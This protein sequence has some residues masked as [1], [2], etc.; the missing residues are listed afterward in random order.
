[1]SR[2]LFP[3][4]PYVLKKTVTYTSIYRKL[5]GYRNLAMCP[6][7]ALNYKHALNKQLSTSGSAI[8]SCALCVEKPALNFNA[9]SGFNST[10]LS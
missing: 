7:C 2:Y 8:F 1:M 10:E 5:S 6:Y 4:V 3:Y 9:P